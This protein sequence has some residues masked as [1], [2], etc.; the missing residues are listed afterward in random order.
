MV[1]TTHS[2][3]SQTGGRVYCSA[4]CH[5]KAKGERYA[6]LYAG[7]AP[8]KRA[9]AARRAAAFS[10]GRTAKTP[11]I[12]G[13]CQVCAT[14]FTTKSTRTKTCSSVCGALRKH[15]VKNRRK[16]LRVL[17]RDAWTCGICTEA[18]DRTLPWPD[19]MS[20]SVDHILPRN[21]GGGDEDANLQA[22]H[23]LCNILKSDTIAA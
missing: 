22:A 21:H 2:L 10:Q 14:P 5:A 12:S 17:E 20:A 8:H 9:V 13:P 11:W 15:R 16:R 19:P 18:I 4:E 1:F 23:L 7:Q 6:V 3:W